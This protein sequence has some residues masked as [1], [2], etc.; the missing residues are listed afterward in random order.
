[1]SSRKRTLAEV[2]GPSQQTPSRPYAPS[3]PHAIRALHQRS[4]A[5]QRS[6]RSRKILADISNHPRPDSARGIL[7]RLAKLTAPFTKRRIETP[8]INKENQRR[9][10]SVEDDDTE[11]PTS[12][13]P[14]VTLSIEEAGED[15]EDSELPTAPTPSAL[16]EDDGDPTV[17]F[18]TLDFSKIADKRPA[19]EK[20]DRRVSRVSFAPNVEGRE[21]DEDDEDD[22]DLTTEIGRRAISEGPPTERLPRYSFGSIRMS[23][24]GNE[25][26]IR[27][28]SDRTKRESLVPPSAL[29]QGASSDGETEDLRRLRRSLSYISDNDTFA[30]IPA[31][32]DHEDTFRLDLPDD[33]QSDSAASRANEPP[34]PA[35]SH[36]FEDFPSDDGFSDNPDDLSVEA[37]DSPLFVPPSSPRTRRQTPLETAAVATSARTAQRRRKPLKLTRSGN[38]V[39]SLPSSFIRRVAIE[40]QTRLG[41]RKPKLGQAHMKALEQATE[42]FF[43]QVGE[44]LATYSSHAGRKKRVD[45]SDVLLLMRRQRVAQ[46]P[47]EL[48]RL[49]K[50]ILSKDVRAELELPEKL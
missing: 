34:L 48:K 35:S 45:Q 11:E 27:R 28:R 47:G 4:G 6:T 8:V 16:L 22:E 31:V 33:E 25:L 42:W 44:D 5:K 43:E 3:T 32:Q 49:A 7:A 9:E 36:D 21:D 46:A 19:S 29:E 41:R 14:N 12:K 24:F 10:V 50:D 30:N 20:S 26:E 40:G 18:K 1:M 39:P 13:R 17:T 15:E 2:S 37:T 38:T 23:D